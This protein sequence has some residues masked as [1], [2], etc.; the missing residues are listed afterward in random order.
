MLIWIPPSRFFL[1]YIFWKFLNVSGVV[2]NV[3]QLVSWGQKPLIFCACSFPWYKYSHS[4]WIH[5]INML[6][7]DSQN[8]LKFDS[9]Q[10]LLF[11]VDYVSGKLCFYL[12]TS[13]FPPHCWMADELGIKFWGWELF[14]QLHLALFK[15]LL[16]WEVYGHLTFFFCG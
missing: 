16:P 6:S 11:Q 8:S 4:G 12:K 3:Y 14:S 2:V 10:S 5:V 9:Y 1:K 7:T 15:L 13:L